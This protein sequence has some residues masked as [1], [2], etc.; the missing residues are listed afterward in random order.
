MNIRLSV[1]QRLIV[2]FFLFNIQSCDKGNPLNNQEINTISD[3]DGNLYHTV[4]IGNQVWTVENLRTA[5]YNDGSEIP[6]VSDSVTWCNLK[7]PGYCWNNYDSSYK[8]KYGALYNWYTINTR[9]LA[10]AGWH[11]P[12]SSDWDTLVIYLINN[13]YNWDGTKG[14]PAFGQ[15]KVGKS[16]AAQTDWVPSTNPGA[17]GNDLTKNNSSGFTA[18]PGGATYGGFGFAGN[19]GGW[20]S[21]TIENDSLYAVDVFLDYSLGSIS[22]SSSEVNCG[23]S[24]RLLKD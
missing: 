4:K 9:K 7:T 16:V 14:M 10:P 6:L 3:A 19:E 22:I 23:Q 15:N 11:I 12:T 5:K 17:V 21:A 20:W 18:L 1:F 24:V 2:L 13:G 8:S